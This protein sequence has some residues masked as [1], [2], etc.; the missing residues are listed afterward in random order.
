MSRA[1]IAIT[2]ILLLIS[3]I[4]SISFGVNC[5]NPKEIC[6][7]PGGARI[8]EGVSVTLP[9]WRY[10]TTWECH[11]D[12]DNNCKV[13]REQG[14]SQISAKCIKMFGDTCAVQEETYDC[15]TTQT[16]V[17]KGLRIGDEFF[18]MSGDCSAVNP[19]SNKN[20]S[21]VAA[22]AAVINA[23]AEDVRQQNTDT[24]RIF[25]G[26]VIECSRSI[27]NAKN[28]CADCGWAKGLLGGCS[29]EEI[30][31]AKAKE[32]GLAVEAGN[33]S[34]H[35]YCHNRV[36]GVCTSYHKVYCVF[37]SKIAR[38]VQVE[39][40]RNQLGIGFGVIGDDD[41]YPDCRG[42]TPEELSRLDFD[43]MDFRS[44]YNDIL[45]KAESML[46][47]PKVIGQRVSESMKSQYE[48]A[49]KEDN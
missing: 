38:I 22:Y 25:T 33:G 12:S 3:L 8:F 15:P 5:I 17:A 29:S 11:E 40:R 32:A 18:C 31:L 27:T 24:P 16:G 19:K 37:P 47:D 39:G 34:N 41:A 35:E 46:P 7:E 23:A 6:V 30:E 42:I 2:V 44:L 10:E 21:Q 28:C 36:L 13:L 49:V 4:S 1:I 26:K 48:S 45:R 43:K 14:C 20:F 9:C